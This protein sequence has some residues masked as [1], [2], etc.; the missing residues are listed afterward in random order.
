MDE[1]PNTA[2]LFERLR[3]TALR[4]FEPPPAEWGGRPSGGSGRLTITYAECP[5]PRVMALALSLAGLRLSG[6]GEKVAWWSTFAFDGVRF[7]LAHQKFGLRLR[8]ANA[9]LSEEEIDLRLLRVKKKL[10]AAVR[11]VEKAINM[12]GRDLV[13]SGDATVLN[14]HRR[15]QQAYDYFRDRAI[16][17][18]KIEDATTVFGDEGLGISGMSFVSG[19]AVM[20]LNST[21]DVVAAVTSFLSRLEHDL[22][23]ALPFAGF[24]S[25]RDHLTDFIGMRWGLKYERVL[26]TSGEA[27]MFM[28]RL[29][30]IVERWRN[31]YTHGGFEKG[32]G[33]T[34]YVH[35][36]GA[37]ALPIGLSAMRGQPY[38]SMSSA[39]D[40]A[41]MDVFALFDQFDAWFAAT[42]P[43]AHAWIVSGLSTRFDREYC[44]LV[45]SLADDDDGCAEYLRY[46]EMEDGR[47]ANMDY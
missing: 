32:N 28:N 35:V 19:A 36:P 13:D 25:D 41:I 33:S 18:T 39:S 38:L 47:A 43:H 22:V 14:Q 44:E 6:P 21:H 17:P 5:I 20:Q 8:I 11:M 7:E 42:K 15:L 40:I 23:L 12:V 24:N 4:G 45:Q 27:K 16:N 3:A 9:G 29:V 30:A 46:A 37:G 1:L 10:L 31:P 34:V 2:E 26:G